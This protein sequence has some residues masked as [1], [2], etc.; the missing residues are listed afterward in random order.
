[1][2]RFFT[3]ATIAGN[4]VTV[5]R[6]EHL[7]TGAGGF[8]DRPENG[9]GENKE[10]NYKATQKRRRE[11]VRNLLTTNFTNADKFVTL[12]FRDSVDFDICD[13]KACNHAFNLF[14]KRLKTWLAKNHPHKTLRYLAVIEFQDKHGRGA[15]H[16][17]LMMNLPFIKKSILAKIWGYG[18]VKIN[19]IDKV[20]NIGAYVSKYMAADLDDVRLQGLKAYQY[21]KNLMDPIVLRNWNSVEDIALIDFLESL[22]GKT[23]SYSA[24]YESVN[25]GIVLYEQYKL[26]K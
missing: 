15:V 3:V 11:S 14:I 7:N 22:K 17:H 18:F 9:T 12:T 16:Y 23:P 21:S 8:V 20:D 2:T 26:G 19:A 13:V 10:E 6:Y 24:K 1:M 5:K 4:I 25:S